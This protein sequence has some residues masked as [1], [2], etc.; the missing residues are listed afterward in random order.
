MGSAGRSDAARLGVVLV[1]VGLLASAFGMTVMAQA[2]PE[3]EPTET[4]EPTAVPIFAPEPT[5]VPTVAPT[6]V[7]EPTAAPASRTSMGIMAEP[8]ELT[9]AALSSP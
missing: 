7:P 5:V 9:V 4:V 1:L 3:A 6:T 8:F 2:T